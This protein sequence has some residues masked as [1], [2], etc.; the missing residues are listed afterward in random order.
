M[1]AISMQLKAQPVMLV[2]VQKHAILVFQ[3]SA[4]CNNNHINKKCNFL[5][6]FRQHGN[7]C[8]CVLDT[9]VLHNIGKS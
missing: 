6:I 7:G 9:S 8:S 1:Q 3:K 4:H 2:N 5:L